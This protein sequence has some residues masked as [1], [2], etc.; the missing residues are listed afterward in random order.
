MASSKLI[1]IGV[2]LGRQLGANTN[3]FIG[4][5]S[6]INF[7]GKGPD[8]GKLFQQDINTEV[9]GGIELKSALPEI[10]TSLGYLT[11]GKLNDIQANKLIDNLTKMNDFY[12]PI[13]GDSIANVTDMASRTGGLT[14]GG[15]DSLRGLNLKNLDNAKDAEGLAALRA[16][17]GDNNVPLRSMSEILR[18]PRKMADEAAFPGE[19]FNAAKAAAA[20]SPLMS[21]LG[22]KIKNIQTQTNDASA[23]METIPK[24][25]IP[26]KTASAREFLLNALNDQNANRT[27]FRDV[28]SPQDLKAITEGGGGV[29]MDP[30][31]LVQKYFGP[32]VAEL[33]PS[34]ATVDDIAIFTQRIL[35][36]ATDAKGLRPTNPEFDKFTLSLDELSEG[37][38]SFG[39]KK[40]KEFQ[41]NVNSMGKGTLKQIIDSGELAGDDLEAALN[42]LRSRKA[43]GGRAR[44]GFA[45]G[46]QDAGAG[47][48]FGKED[49]GGNQDNTREQYGA[50]G[51]YNT[52]PISTNNNNDGPPTNVTNPFGYGNNAPTNVTNHLGSNNI[53]TAILNNRT[54]RYGTD[55]EEDTTGLAGITFKNMT[56][57]E[58]DPITENTQLAK[59]FNTKEDLQSLGAAKKGYFNTLTDQ[60]EALEKFRKNATKMNQGDYY[61]DLGVQSQ[62][63]QLLANEQKN[64]TQN[65]DFIQKS[66]DAGFLEDES[67]FINQKPLNK[68]FAEGGRANYRFGGL[69][70]SLLKK[71]NTKKIKA[72]VDDIFPS[73]DYKY[74]AEMAAEALVENNPKLFGGQL[75]DDLD[76][77]IR[78]DV[79]GLVLKELS[80]RNALKLQATR[81]ARS[82]GPVVDTT[83]TEAVTPRGFS[84]NVERAMS[85]L[86]IPREEAERIA[87]LSSDQ[88]KLAVQKYLDRDFSQRITL[89]DYNPKKFDAAKG[90]LAKILEV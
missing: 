43:D 61:K 8:E 49:Y 47:S 51:Q 78:S 32:R 71:L 17:T 41:N 13:T 89:G 12:Y 55:P 26:G 22:D 74:D 28:V 39:Y 72:A 80:Q 36:D 56:G 67:D 3:K 21:R 87:R 88:Q 60:G 10:E 6:N 53:R 69:T 23:I 62:F 79:Y 46:G 2:K 18:N 90:G 50:V 11:A 19:T 42:A 68:A 35:N 9:L 85:D 29:D 27:V 64:E 5:R 86:N 48:D 66:I 73:G 7:L 81:A 58:P 63:N 38:Y 34:N 65:K 37:T 20:E 33:L 59:V 76:D 25:E 4:T 15:L 1:D 52:E 75:Y 82:Q 77:M 16:R 40:G 14:R 83:I 54:S 57:L 30:I 31:V 24:N 70:K 44:V 45:G 84:L